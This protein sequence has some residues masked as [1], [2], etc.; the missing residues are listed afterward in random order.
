MKTGRHARGKAADL[1]RGLG[2]MR[3]LAH[4]PLKDAIKMTKDVPRKW[5]YG[6]WIDGDG[7]P[8]GQT[9]WDNGI[10][11]VAGYFRQM[12]RFEKDEPTSLQLYNR[13]RKK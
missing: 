7:R 4:H 13:R 10:E 11:N 6:G 1:L 9:A 5:H 12:F 8:H 3:L 2:A